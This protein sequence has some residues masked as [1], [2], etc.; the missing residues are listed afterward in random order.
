MYTELLHG[1]D[2]GPIFDT[3]TNNA[4][5]V[6]E[7]TKVA[8]GSLPEE[9]VAFLRQAP[10]AG[11]FG[12]DGAVFVHSAERLSGTPDGHFAVDFLY[13]TCSKAS[14]DVLA[15]ASHPD[16]EDGIPKYLLQI[17]GD[18]S[19]N[20]FCLDLRNATFGKVYFWDHEHGADGTGLHLV[21]SD[22]EAFVNSLAREPS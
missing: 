9:Y 20:A 12:G 5:L 1:L 7:L 21:A 10:V 16:G 11:M 6:D 15:L 22:F 19:G 2:Y 8:G 18:L 4:A 17:G 13:A 14:Y 3:D